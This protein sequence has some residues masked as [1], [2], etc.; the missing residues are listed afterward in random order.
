MAEKNTEIL[1]GLEVKVI[2]ITNENYKQK[3]EDLEDVRAYLLT[4]YPKNKAKDKVISTEDITSFLAE[5]NNDGAYANDA[6]RWLVIRENV[7]GKEKGKVVGVIAYDV[8]DVPDNDGLQFT[9]IYYLA[10]DKGYEC[11]VSRILSTDVLRF[12]KKYSSDKGRKNI[13]FYTDETAGGN[14]KI[15]LNEFI[16]QFGRGGYLYRKLGV[17][18]LAEIPE[19]KYKTV[20]FKRKC[21][22]DLVFIPFCKEELTANIAKRMV[23]SYL[24]QGYNSRQPGERGYIPLSKAPFYEEFVRKLDKRSPDGAVGLKPIK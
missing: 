6:Y 16:K 9:P 15:I 18:T 20:N 11:A 7:E 8:W 4:T 23:F 5:K 21:D 14:R 2:T 13:G 24:D 19:N 17:P 10:A 22:V 1:G 3:S 12:A